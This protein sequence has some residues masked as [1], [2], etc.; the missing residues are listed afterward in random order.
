M[1]ASRGFPFDQKVV[2]EPTPR[3]KADCRLARFCVRLG[4]ESLEELEEESRRNP[5]RFWHETLQDLGIEFRE[6]YSQVLDLS[7]GIQR[8][9]WC[10]GGRMNIVQ[11]CLDKWQ[12]GETFN[13]ASKIAI[14]EEREDGSTSSIAYSQ[15]RDR[16]GQAANALAATGLRQGDVIG[17][18]MPMTSEVVVALLAVLKIGGIALP[19][20]S[21]FGAEALIARLGAAGAQGLIMSEKFERN[22][23]LVDLRPA[24]REITQRVSCL[25]HILVEG[26][27]PD[28]LLQAEQPTIYDW[29]S[30]VASQSTLADNADTAADEACM[31]IYTSG[32]TGQPKGIVHSHCG[33]PL[34]AAQDLGYGFDVGRDDTVFWYTDLGWMMGPWMVLGTLLLG[35]RVLLYDGGP[36]FPEPNR[37]WDICDRHGV[38]VLGISPSVARTAQA[39]GPK[40]VEG[41][42]LKALRCIGS[43]GSPWDT[44]AWMWVYKHALEG[45]KPIFNY[46]GGTEIS[47]GIAGCTYM[48]GLKPSSFNMFLPGIQGDVVDAAGLSLVGEVGELVVR[49]PWIGMARGFWRDEEDRYAA[50]YWSTW[51]HLWKQ[52]DLAVKDE[53]GFWFVLGRSDDTMNIADKRIGPGEYEE[54]LITHPEVLEAAAISV[55][56]AIKGQVAVCFCV[57]RKGLDANSELEE[58]LLDRVARR[59][60]RP[61]RPAAIVFVS[62]LPRTR[63]A[64]L[65]RRLIQDVYLG[66]PLGDTSNLENEEALHALT[67]ALARLPGPSA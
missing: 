29:Q 18:C 22:G 7:P 6:P 20:F 33:F 30:L 21:G 12:R 37:L 1:N 27:R 59:M 10:V 63:S 5:A 44:R 58:S 17:I 32:T 34:K 36:M 40:W 13:P 24:L 43:S 61:L 66:R 52:G 67:E 25:Q 9:R 23:K 45:R 16:V 31:I 35:G 65:M 50:T 19:L 3:Q 11:N 48:R 39:Q 57:V 38:T 42:D 8:P 54:A 47:G 51:P 2:W 15:L 14:T 28:V 53:E 4:C 60:G 41:S 46:T 55:P 64:K 26:I 62:Q 56:H 49:Q